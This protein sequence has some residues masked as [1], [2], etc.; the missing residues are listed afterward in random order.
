MKNSTKK[1][2]RAHDSTK[3]RVAPV[4]DA[5]RKQDR[6]GEKWLS[7]LLSLPRAG[8]PIDAAL[9]GA[10]GAVGAIDEARWDSLKNRKRREKR[11]APPASLL[12]WLVRHLG[13]AHPD[14]IEGK[15]AKA[16]RR[17]ALQAGDPATVAKAL[18]KLSSDPRT[19]AWY[20]LEG[21][22]CPDVFLSTPDALV[23]IEGKRTEAGP[24]KGTTW[25]PGRHRIL[26]HMDAAYEI[27]GRRPVLGFF[28]VEGESESEFPSDWLEAA[29]E[30]L[31]PEAIEHSL[32]HRP[33][34]EREA[35][36]RGF[37]GVTTWQEVCDRCGL[38]RG[39]LIDRV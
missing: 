24:T 17:R 3:T 28:I 37:L 2:R 25:L 30:T 20:V 36:A 35:I 7:L 1:E 22:S 26:R 21:Q 27:A 6:T 16:G 11:L 5:L 4:F 31:S 29:H 38:D 23:V 33:P 10:T 32:P 13:E 8:K 14:D 12:S 18:A 15:D 9:A 34:A 19:R 39:I